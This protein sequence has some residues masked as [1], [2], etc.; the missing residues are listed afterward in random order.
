MKNG[1]R[2]KVYKIAMWNC[3]RGL[4]AS[5][6]QTT[7]KFSEVLNFIQSKEPHLF[8]LIESD[9]HGIQSRT[10]RHKYLSTED[11]H[12]NLKICNYNIYLPMS[13]ELYGQARILLYAHESI[14]IKIKNFGIQYY[15]L[16]ML[17]CEIGLG[18]ERKTVVNFFYREFTGGISGLS[19]KQSQHER[20]SRMINVWNMINNN[21]DHDILCLGDANLCAKTWSKEDYHLKDFS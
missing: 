17:T 10:H 14:K 16:P 3:R 12:E 1:N 19:D 11:I 5:D 18:L 2:E 20:L 13:W 6:G 4:I 15:D 8:C 21:S 9:L 7:D